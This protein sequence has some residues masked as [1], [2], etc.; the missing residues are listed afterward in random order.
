MDSSHVP[1]IES[2]CTAGYRSPLWI[3]AAC[4][5]EPVLVHRQHG[6]AISEK[7]IFAIPGI[8]YFDA[9]RLD[10]L[11][12]DAPELQ[13]RRGPAISQNVMPSKILLRRRTFHD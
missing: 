12:L 4:D 3:C 2:S 5:G 7:K 10:A 11:L 6:K 1:L 8:H 9:H 13:L